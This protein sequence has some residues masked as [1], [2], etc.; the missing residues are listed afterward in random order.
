ME[1]QGVRTTGPFTP[2]TYRISI[3]TDGAL[4]GSSRTHAGDWRGSLRAQPTD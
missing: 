3:A 4:S 1:L 2:D